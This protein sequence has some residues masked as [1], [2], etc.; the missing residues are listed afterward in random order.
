[1]TS[2]RWLAIILIM[3]FLVLSAT[4]FV[5]SVHHGTEEGSCETAICTFNVCDSGTPVLAAGMMPCMHEARDI[6]L[7]PQISETAFAYPEVLPEY[8]LVTKNERPPSV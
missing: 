2:M 7:L 3:A 8:I 4:P 1:M 6:A 5:C